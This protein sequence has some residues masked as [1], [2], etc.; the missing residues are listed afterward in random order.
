LDAVRDH[1]YGTP[2]KFVFVDLEQHGQGY[3]NLP[4]TYSSAVMSDKAWQMISGLTTMGVIPGIYSRST[5]IESFA[6]DLKSWMYRYPVWFASYPFAPGRIT[7]NWEELQAKYAPKIFSPYYNSTWDATLRQASMWQ[8]SGDKFVLPGVFGDTL[9]TRSMPVDLNYTSNALFNLWK[10]AEGGEPLPP[11]PVHQYE[12]WRCLAP[13]GMIVRDAPSRAGVDRGLR[14]KFNELMKVYDKVSAEGITWGRI[15]V[16]LWVG[17]NWSRKESGQV[18]LPSEPAYELWQCKATN[19][20]KVR[21]TPS[22]SGEDTMI[23]ISY[24]ATFKV[25][26]KKAADGYNWGRI[27]IDQWVALNWSVKL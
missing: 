16:N 13:L 23:R 1:I 26:E 22:T 9:G 7:L 6:K 5:W 20:M 11:P 3:L 21:K 10:V 14:I 12:V 8:W 19:G 27:G 2:I 24:N 4:P 15:G 17:L 18:E 25:Y